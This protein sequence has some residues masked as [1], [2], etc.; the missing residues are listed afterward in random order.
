LKHFAHST[1]GR[2]FEKDKLGLLGSSLIFYFVAIDDW[3]LP[4]HAETY[5]RL[6]TSAPANNYSLKARLLSVNKNRDEVEVF[7]HDN[8]RA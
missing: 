2:H 7:I 3:R 8:H 6:G 1:K 4:M 5:T